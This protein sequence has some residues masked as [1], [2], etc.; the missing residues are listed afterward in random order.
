MHP[1]ETTRLPLIY[2]EKGYDFRKVRLSSRPIP[3]PA[4][5]TSWTVLDVI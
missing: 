1:Y 5:T 2:Y 4:D 3:I